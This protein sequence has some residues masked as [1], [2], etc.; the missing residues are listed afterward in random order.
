MFNKWLF[1]SFLVGA[2]IG[3]CAGF[4]LDRFVLIPYEVREVEKFDLL[5]VYGADK[6]AMQREVN[7]CIQVPKN[8]SIM[9]KL[10]IIADRLSRFRFDYLPIEVVKI[11][12]CDDTSIAIINLREFENLPN[13]PSWRYHYFQGTTGGHFT[14]LTLVDTFLQKEYKGEWIGGVRFMYENQPIKENDWD[15]IG[16]SGI[17]LRE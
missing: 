9:E 12:T 15:H 3:V 5:R 14:T 11:E 7:F 6:H 17:I 16:L 1:L 2:L 8:L 4:F 13:A 10:E